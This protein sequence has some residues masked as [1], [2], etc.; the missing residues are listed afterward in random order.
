[1]FKFAQRFCL[2]LADALARDAE[3]LADL[4]QRVIGVHANAKAHAQHALLTRG[5]AGKHPRRGL[6]QIGM[7]RRI[8]WLDSILVLDEIAQMAVCLVAD[9]RLKGNRLL[10]NFQHL[11][12]LVDRH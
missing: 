7:D 5:Q 6:A 12:D 3:L 8:K 2:N 4:F 10:G 1:M 11:A 9:G